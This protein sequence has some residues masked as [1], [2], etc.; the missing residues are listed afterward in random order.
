MNIKLIIA[1]DGGQY[2]GWQ[3]TFTGPSIEGTLQETL[4]KIL[5]EKIILQA[6]SRTDAGVH[7]HGQVVNFFTCKKKLCIKKL[8]WSLN[9][10]LP[11]DIVVLKA[12][13]ESSAF[14]PTLDCIGKEY[15]Y[16]ICF[17]IAQFPNYRFYS[18][19]YPYSLNIENM[20]KAASY[21]IGVHDFS[22]FCNFKKN[23]EYEHTIR[24]IN[25][26]RID[27]LPEERLCIKICGTNF[28]YK[29]VRNI[30]GTLA[31]VGKGKIHCDEI[32]KILASCDRTLAGVTAP[33][34]GLTLYKVLY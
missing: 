26:I 7:A 22:A 16:F 10:L 6:A 14:H 24:E 29:M 1:Y 28:L 32:P 2:L 9:S 17:G 12:E 11:K 4:E 23:A 3:K 21:F 19:H 15:H 25:Q 33:A 5:Q 34:H 13:I 18:W 31:Y 20:K 27:E 8:I 30:V